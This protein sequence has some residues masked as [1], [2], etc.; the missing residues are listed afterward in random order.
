[1]RKLHTTFQEYTWK[2]RYR[3]HSKN[4]QYVATRMDLSFRRSNTYRQGL[5]DPQA[6]EYR[7][8]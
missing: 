4:A 2:E 5:L 8:A 7:G 1:M 3:G 6:M